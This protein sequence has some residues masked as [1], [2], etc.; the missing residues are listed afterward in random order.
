MKKIILTAI[1]CLPAFW[2]T[3]CKENV[4][5]P[6]PKKK[7]NSQPQ[8]VKE[9]ELE[10]LQPD[11]KPIIKINIEVADNDSERQQGLMN[12]AFMSYDRGMLFIFDK[13]APQA[14]W[15]KNTIIPL[16]IIYVNSNKEI[17][18]IAENTQPYS[19]ASLPSGKPAIFVVE[20]N[21]GFCA[22]N[23]IQRGNKISFNII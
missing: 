13:E 8:F 18:S 22:Q 17:V 5:S 4:E 2:M 11:G 23:K 9:G 14:F 7:T 1:I 19:E 10:F 12:R 3:G 15:M 20:V 16:D 6:E 21:A